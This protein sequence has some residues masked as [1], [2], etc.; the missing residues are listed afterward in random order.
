M[1]DETYNGW[2]NYPTW[3]TQLWLENDQST[4]NAV[5]AEV[6]DAM[7]EVE[8][9]AA[10]TYGADTPPDGFGRSI[11]GDRIRAFVSELG[12]DMG[13]HGLW[14]DLAGYALDCVNWLELADAW[15]E[16]VSA[17]VDC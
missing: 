8:E 4:Y 3:V 12:P 1:S 10:R 5:Y 17:G 9:V 6:C 13:E 7:V 2:T 15:I 16:S 14:A 11:I